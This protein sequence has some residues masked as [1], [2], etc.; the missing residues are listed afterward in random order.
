MNQ[1]IDLDAR[2]PGTDFAREALQSSRFGRSAAISA[3]RFAF[4]RL[5]AHSSVA[6]AARCRRSVKPS[7]A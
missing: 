5:I 1:H 7:F 4:E 6:D 3:G 2:N